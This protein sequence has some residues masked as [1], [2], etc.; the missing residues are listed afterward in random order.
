[1]ALKLK[2]TSNI[3]YILLNDDV[4]GDYTHLVMMS[5]GKSLREEI[6]KNDNKLLPKDSLIYD[7][8]YIFKV[9]DISQEKGNFFSNSKVTISLSFVAEDKERSEEIN[10]KW[11]KPTKGKFSGTD[12]SEKIE[13]NGMNIKIIF[14]TEKMENKSHSMC[15]FK[16]L[17]IKTNLEDYYSM[18]RNFPS[19]GEML[20]QKGGGSIIIRKRYFLTPEY[21]RGT[22]IPPAKNKQELQQRREAYYKTIE[23]GFVVDTK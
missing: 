10:K 15:E 23:L 12:Y 13:I 1:M 8:A 18:F 16:T 17:A 22:V 5:L 2:L 6:K 21:V 20:G 9:A 3:D 19:V 14:S 11:E 4:F 7:G